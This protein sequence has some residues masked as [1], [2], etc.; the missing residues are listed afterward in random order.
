MIVIVLEAV[1]PGCCAVGEEGG[2]GEGEGE[3][4]KGEVEQNLVMSMEPV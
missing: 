3:G 4:L 2:R 1:E